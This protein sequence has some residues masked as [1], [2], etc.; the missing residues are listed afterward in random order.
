MKHAI[1][2]LV[3]SFLIAT[4]IAQPIDPSKYQSPVKVACIGNSITYGSGIENRPLNSYPAQLQ[5]M[6]GDK[7]IVRN[8]GVGGRTLLKKG[9]FPFWNEEAYAQAKAFLPDVVIIK[10]GTND[11]KPQNWKYSGEFLADYR[12]MVK[13]LKALS[14]HPKIYLCKPVPAYASRWG[15]NDS[16]VVHGVIPA[17]EK[18]AKEENLPVIDLYSALSGKA[19]LFPDQIHPN[20][21]GAGLMSKA[22][23]KALTG[24]DT[25]PVQAQYPGKLT[26]WHGFTKYDFQIERRNVRIVVP[27][28]A[29][30]GKPWVWRARFP[31]WHYQM[32]S[33]LIRKGFHVVYIDTD[34]LFGSPQCVEIWNNFYNYLTSQYGLNKKVALEGVSRGGLYVFNFAKKY[35][36]R[37][38]TIYA[39]APVCDFKSWPAGKGT[40]KGDPESWQLL[41][42]AYNFKTEKEALDYTDN[43]INNLE[44]LAAA[45]VPLLFQIGL[46]DS[47]VPP[48]ENTYILSEK[49]IRLGGPAM[50]YPNT[51]GKQS[52]QGH[53]FPIDDIKGAADFI[54]NSYP[55]VNPKLDSRNYHTLRNK[56]HNAQMVFEREKKGRVA[57]LG[58]SITANGGWRDSI[59]A[60]L[61]KRFPKT[62]FDFIAA[63]IPSFG[64]TPGAIRF[65]RDVL[66]N[67]KVDLLFE[68][69]AVNDRVNGFGPET[70]IL[71]MEG[72]VRHARESNPA[73]DIV[74]MHFVDPDKMAEYR[75]GI[76]PAEIQNHEKVAAHYGV[77]TINLAKEVTERIDNGEFTWENDFKNLH[78][79]P[80]GQH[81]YYQSMK[82]LLDDCWSGFVADDDK[83]TAY[84]LPA[85]LNSSS[86]DK[87]ILIQAVNAKPAKGW[88]AVQNWTPTDN[89]G[90]RDDFTKVPM[91]VAET[92]GGILKYDFEGSAV[93]IAVASG[94]D[95]GIIEYRIDKGIWKKQDLFT[96][97]SSSLHLPWFY[98]LGYGLKEGKHRLEIK[99]L[100]E[101]NVQSKGNACRIRYFYVNN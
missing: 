61:Q 31:D 63:G 76:T 36:E 32:D 87:G 46:H 54:R 45:K 27:D 50:I 35:P 18:L 83:L 8:F 77:S 16:I 49:Y 74:V 43:P 82:V 26:D 94:S 92:S 79:S 47:I 85:K 81:I 24:K 11:T 89:T 62:K 40:G 23:Y 33:I 17:V 38:S 30:P 29:A 97:W 57:F 28:K 2:L 69:A 72:I 66:K 37:V 41:M 88:Q 53:H 6:L 100:P 71:G 22:I 101:K 42:K 99:V 4:G 34:F 67:G 7:W 21:E 90:T 86:Y 68:E 13:E 51:K 60:Y 56:L 14:S 10:L 98:T 44:K 9:D 20:A 64:S 96:Q 39:E 5:R 1:L 73:M 84:P 70:Q 95:A 55:E 52:L 58:G 75:K 3:F 25:Q 59:C 65:E 48:D 12:A 15:I 80:F 19:S 78:P 91:L 93:G